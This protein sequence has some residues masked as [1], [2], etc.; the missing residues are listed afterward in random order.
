MKCVLKRRSSLFL[1]IVV[2]TISCNKKFKHYSTAQ[3]NAIPG[4][5]LCSNADSL[6]GTYRGYFVSPDY[7]TSPDTINVDLE[8]IFLSLGYEQDSTVMFFKLTKHFNNGVDKL[9]FVS[10]NNNDGEFYATETGEILSIINDSLHIRET[11]ITSSD[12]E[13]GFKF[14][15]KKIP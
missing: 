9:T 13:L 15:G 8:H 5:L 4:C 12:S 11:H 10:I 2:L 3:L 7:V 14:D 1:L 6:E